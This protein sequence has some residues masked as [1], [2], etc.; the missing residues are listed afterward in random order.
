MQGNC[1]SPAPDTFP[2]PL[3]SKG[4]TQCVMLLTALL[5]YMRDASNLWIDNIHFRGARTDLAK[6]VSY[7]V[8]NCDA[9]RGAMRVTHSTFQGDGGEM[10]GVGTETGCR[11]Y[12]SGARRCSKLAAMCSGVAVAL[13]RAHQGRS[14]VCASARR[15]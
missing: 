12:F 4:P 10:R 7:H 1:S 8:L 14:A 9:D 2:T 13:R 15:L 11:S 6:P 3:K 5:F